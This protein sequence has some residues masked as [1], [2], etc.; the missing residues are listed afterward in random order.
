MK[1]ANHYTEHKQTYKN[2]SVYL[3]DKPHKNE[4]EF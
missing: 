2:L 3:I 1:M 4:V